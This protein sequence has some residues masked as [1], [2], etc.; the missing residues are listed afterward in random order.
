MKSEADI[1][2]NMIED[3][4]RE[5]NAFAHKKRLNDPIVV[6]LSQE[7]D[8]LLNDYNAMTNVYALVG[9]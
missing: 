9:K 5:L 6:A 3:I 7:L 1:L 4:R 2:L 8:C